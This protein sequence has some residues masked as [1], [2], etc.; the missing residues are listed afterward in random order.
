MG[1]NSYGRYLEVINTSTPKVREYLK[2]VLRG[3]VYINRVGMNDD[4][5][6]GELAL[7]Y[8]CSY[9]DR[10]FKY[11]SYYVVP[12]AILFF[13]DEACARIERGLM[14]YDSSKLPLNTMWIS[15]WFNGIEYVFDPSFSVVGTKEAFYRYY[16][17]Y[18]LNRMDKFD[19][20]AG[21]I[22]FVSADV[23]RDNFF[24]TLAGQVDISRD[25]NMSIVYPW[26]W[27]GVSTEVYP[28][29]NFSVFVHD[30]QWGVTG[31][32]ERKFVRKLKVSPSRYV[33]DISLKK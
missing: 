32:C 3:F 9:D 14:R 33:G 6:V 16:E 27:G 29:H 31:D 19:E 5:G 10:V 1:L 7:D 17:V 4:V 2:D 25:S 21:K 22:R 28:I 11:E 23:V 12:G 8:D 13:P 15:F 26:R 24:D 30:Q 20:S 18:E